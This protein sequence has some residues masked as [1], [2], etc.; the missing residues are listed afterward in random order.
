MIC[1][2]SLESVISLIPKNSKVIP[3]NISNVKS[4]TTNSSIVLP[5]NTIHSFVKNVP[6]LNETITVESSIN[7]FMYVGSIIWITIIII[8]LVYSIVTYVRFY[9]LIKTATIVE[10]NIYETDRITTPFVLG[11]IKPKIYLPTN[12]DNKEYEYIVSHEQCHIK[13]KDYII[14]PLYFIGVIIHWFNPVMWLSY[15]LM[16]KDME[17]S[18][19][20]KVLKIKGEDTKTDYAKTLLNLSV[21]QSNLLNPIAFGENNTKSRIKNIIK[22][23]NPKFWVIS[24]GVVVLIIACVTLITNPKKDGSRN[25]IKN[26]EEDRESN[27]YNKSIGGEKLIIKHGM[28]GTVINR[29]TFLELMKNSRKDWIEKKVKKSL[30]I[31]PAFTVYFNFNSNEIRFYNSDPKVIMVINGDNNNYYNIS[32]E[33]Y[34]AVE[35]KYM[36]SSYHIPGEFI[37]L[38][39]KGEKTNI[40]SINDVPINIEKYYSFNLGDNTYYIYKN[41][42]KYYC[43]SPY[44]FIKEISEDVYNK[45]LKIITQTLEFSNLQQPESDGEEIKEINEDEMAITDPLAQFIEVRLAKITASPM[46]S[47]NPEDYIKENDEAYEEII[48]FGGEEGLNYMLE[49]FKEDNAKGIRGEIMK[50]LCQELLGIRSNV[51]DDALSAEEWFKRL[52][53][54]EEIKLP[55]FEYEGNNEIEK[56]VYKTEIEQNKSKYGE[57]TIVAPHIFGSYSEGNKLKVF[58]TTVS[59]SYRL[60]AKFLSHEGG[61]VVPSAITYVKNKEGNYV[62]E[63]YEMAMDGAYF[64]TSVEEFC[65]MPESNKKIKGLSD[66]IFK[67]Y[68]DYED[69]LKLER[70]NLI[71]HLNK[72]KQFGVSLQRDYVDPPDNI[73]PLT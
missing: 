17:M 48:K 70:K 61:S 44:E 68:G 65:V 49:Q 64:G 18:C 23:K 22:Y 53:V 56:L 24:L 13:R 47:S 32:N 73:I 69:I 67:H 39:V 20:E 14:K 60:F 33:V 52:K 31:S 36:V 15:Y 35:F 26:L 12:I 50:T 4:A 8:I 37:D 9:R 38:V 10:K 21:K 42:N 71:R 40:K 3:E 5:N 59:S 25:Y 28:G 46:E 29:K 62:L 66:K 63:N 34:D 11:F 2:F 51:N 45:G 7:K 72:Y 30:D 16:T 6:N 43:E 1:P 19:D 41:N 55:N 57:F 54:R 58:V 27:I